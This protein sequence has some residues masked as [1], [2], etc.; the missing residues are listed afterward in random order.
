MNNPQPKPDPI[1]RIESG[2]CSY[3]IGKK[4]LLTLMREVHATVSGE[5]VIEDI[6]GLEFTIKLA[7]E[8]QYPLGTGDLEGCP[9]EYAGY[10]LKH[11]K[12]RG[13]LD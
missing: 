13:Y 7:D 1:L 5:S 12:L 3:T 8:G 11:D 6:I 9:V 4:A 2:N 10:L